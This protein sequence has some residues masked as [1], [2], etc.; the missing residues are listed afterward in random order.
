MRRYKVCKGLVQRFLV[1]LYKMTND[2][3]SA[4]QSLGLVLV[5][6]HF[7]LGLCGLDYNSSMDI[8]VCIF[9]H[10]F[11]SCVVMALQLDI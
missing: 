10:P 5:S 9:T 6:M 2:L 3:V 1:F 8:R 11:T 7:G 4:L